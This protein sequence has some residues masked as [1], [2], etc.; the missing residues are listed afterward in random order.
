VLAFE[1]SNSRMARQEGTDS[2][3]PN[4][5]AEAV[6]RRCPRIVPTTHNRPP[7]IK[8]MSRELFSYHMSSSLARFEEK[9]R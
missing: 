3:R 4:F 8:I 2:V 7:K 9:F 1:L 6:P 5:F